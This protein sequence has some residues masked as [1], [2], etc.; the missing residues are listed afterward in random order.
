MNHYVQLS[1]NRTWPSL[2]QDDIEWSLRYASG[3]EVENIRY[4][5]AS[6]VAAYMEIIRLNPGQRNKLCKEILKKQKEKE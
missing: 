4:I 2:D 5:A 6:I 3:K 1:E